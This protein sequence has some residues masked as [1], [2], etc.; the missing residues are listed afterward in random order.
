[1]RVRVRFKFMAIVSLEIRVINFGILSFKMLNQT[2]SVLHTALV[3]LPIDKL[4]LCFNFK[5]TDNL[6]S[7]SMRSCPLNKEI[8]K[9][10]IALLKNAFKQKVANHTFS[11]NYKYK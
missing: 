11:A 7:R 1:M 8:N 6:Q 10:V 2:L 5:I 9:I 4:S 3:V